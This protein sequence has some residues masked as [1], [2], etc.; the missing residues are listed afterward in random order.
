MAAPCG[1]SQLPAEPPLKVPKMEVLSPGSPS[2]LSDGNPSL[3]DPSTPSGASPLGTGPPAGGAGRG[4][5][6]PSVSFSPGAAAAAA[7]ACRGM[8]WTPAETNALIAVWG[9]ERLVEARYQQLEGAGTVFGSKAPGPAMYERVSRALAELGYERTPSQCRERIKQLHKRQSELVRNAEYTL[10]RCY[11]RVK[12]H[13]VGKRKSSYT[14]EQLEQVFGQGGWDSQPCQPVLINSSGLY[15]ELESDSSTMEEFS[16]E[17][18][19][20]H[21]QDLHCY[22]TGEQELDEIPTTKRT[23]KIKQESSEDAQKRDVM[24]NIMQILES[25]QLKWE[26]FQSWT[27]FS[28]LHLSNK[29]AIF[30]IGYNTRWK[31]DIRYHYAEISSQVPLG[32]RLREYFNSEKPEGRVIMTRVQK[33]NWKNV[34]YKFLEITISEA[35]CLELHME[36]DW[37]PIAHS[38]PTG[39]NVVQYLLPGGIPKSP[40][41][42]AIGYEECH[43]KP[44]SSPTEHRAPDPGTETQ[45]ELEVPSPQ[46]SLRVDMESAR[47]IYCYLGIAEVRTLQQCLFL[48]F[49]ANTKTFSKDWVG[50]NAFLSQNCLV[51][52]GVSPKSIYIKFVE[53]ERDFLSAGSLVECLEKAIGY[54][55]KFNN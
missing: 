41:L 15:Q 12:E 9:N 19:G 46:A 32:K 22:Q 25:V 8:S 53:V 2:A 49:Q 4:G 11:S 37:I 20:N 42:Y 14:F 31:E 24:Q 40:G 52:P 28:R 44:P 38:K 1:S 29:L 30:G 21:S 13:G 6:S 17:D 39:G 3:S 16:Q 55:L 18:W 54:P 10:R 36:I 50:I 43:E 51:E 35:R 7:A 26:L 5:A 45:G 47:I 48:H 27:D 23:L 34:Y 33:M